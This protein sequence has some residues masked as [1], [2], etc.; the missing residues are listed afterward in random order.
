MT[1]ERVPR[2]VIG[3]VVATGL[4]SFCGVIIETAMN[5][6]FPT[7][8]R[9]FDVG[10]ST[11][12]WLTTLYLLVVAAIVPLSATL[13]RTLRMKTLFL[14]ANGLFLLGVA[15]DG[16]APTFAILLLGRGVQ[17]LGTG[18]ALPLMFN[19]ILAQVP[20]SK[21]GLMM[22]LGTM[23]TGVAPAI[24]PTFGGVV[25]ATLS[26]R[27]IFLFLTPVLLGSLVLGSLT[28]VQSEPLTRPRVDGLSVV[29]IIL[30]F[31]GLVY[32]VANATG[33]WLSWS[34]A[35][36]GSFGVVCLALFVWRSSLLAHPVVALTSFRQ[37]AFA[38]Q[39]GAFVAI[40][41]LALALSFILPNYVQLVDGGSALAAGLTVLPGAAVGAILAPLA[42][43]VYDRL[44]PRWPILGGT[45]I[46][47]LGLGQFAWVGRAMGPATIIGVYL[48]FMLGIGLAF[49]NIMTNALA[50]LPEAAQ[51]D[52]N[53][54]MT[55][56]QQFAA[57]MGTSLAA[58]LVAGGQ[59]TKGPLAV[60]TALGATHAFIVLVGLCGVAFLS[61]AWALRR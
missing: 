24:G 14:I 42:G 6:T 37:P 47:L 33:A 55:T 58:T 54:I 50:A 8:M 41:M 43:R 12:Q 17:G 30:A 53:A 28:I 22:G 20:R 39:V 56:L 57:A 16:L 5:I 23:I 9:Q 61:L 31:V 59:A 4:L 13:K 52:G 3:A 7:L 48:V 21:I 40:Q 44:G 10:T 36:A 51:S 46:M 26:W 18:I 38:A 32:A 11:V 49:G 15:L 29:T 45:C 19:I 35:G 1:D 60:G 27:Y 25:V 2:R 34:V